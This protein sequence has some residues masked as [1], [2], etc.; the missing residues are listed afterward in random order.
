MVVPHGVF[1]IMAGH[2]ED[3]RRNRSRHWR[4]DR[5]VQAGIHGPGSKNIQ[6]HLIGD[7]LV[8]R[9]QGI[10]TAAEQ[11]LVKMLPAEK[12]RV[13]LMCSFFFL[14]GLFLFGPDSILS[15]AAAMDFGTKKG[16]GTATGLV[17]GIGA[18]G[19]ILGGFLP[20]VIASEKDWSPV[21]YLIIGGLL[22]S[23]LVLLP[24][25]KSLPP[26]AANHQR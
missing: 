2:D 12:G 7:L 8:V 11:H 20:G 14:I 3:T 26:P 16:A 18:I 13:W 17:N 6:A 24:F 5:S 10:L 23:V 22:L 1:G 19:G 4:R 9:L 25:W 21:F 15:G